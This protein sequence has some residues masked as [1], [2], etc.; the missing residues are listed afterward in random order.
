MRGAE[1][2]QEQDQLPAGREDREGRGAH[3]DASALPAVAQHRDEEVGEG[4]HHEPEED[5]VDEGHADLRRATKA[6]A[7]KNATVSRT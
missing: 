7:A 4:G 3:R 2:G 1:Q 5:G 6:T